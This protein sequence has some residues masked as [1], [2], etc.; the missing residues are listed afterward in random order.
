MLCH[1]LLVDRKIPDFAL[2]NLVDIDR[3]L[4][5]NEKY[6]DYLYY[7]DTNS[8]RVVIGFTKKF[9][10]MYNEKKEKD[11]TQKLMSRAKT[12]V[13]RQIY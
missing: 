7:L 2:F 6:K 10:F 5:R 4:S 12:N 3:F 11:E 8:N 1:Y 13:P 9:L